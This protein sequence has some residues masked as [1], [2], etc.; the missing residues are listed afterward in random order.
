[1]FALNKAAYRIVCLFHYVDDTFVF[2]SDGP[3]KLNDLLKHL[4]SMHPNIQFSMETELDG[5]L[6]FL[7]INIYRRP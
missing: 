1:M 3:G 2:W 6:S 4:K 7:D 5:H